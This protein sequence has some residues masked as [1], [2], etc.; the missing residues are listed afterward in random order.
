MPPDPADSALAPSPPDELHP[1]TPTRREGK[2]K[3]TRHMQTEGATSR[4]ISTGSGL[5]DGLVMAHRT[6]FRKDHRL[7]LMRTDRLPH[8]SCVQTRIAASDRS[9]EALQLHL[10][11]AQDATFRQQASWLSKL[12]DGDEQR[13]VAPPGGERGRKQ[14]T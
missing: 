12:D 14:A 4:F 13:D 6:R 7:E 5:A 2:T 10:T 3:G 11:G 1:A 8:E 9:A